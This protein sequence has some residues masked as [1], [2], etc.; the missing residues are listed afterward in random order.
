M[1]KLDR[2]CATPPACL[3]SYQHG[4]HTWDDVSGE[5]KKEIH[6][7]LEQM[8]G[9]RCAYCEGPL[10]SLGWHIE[11]FRRKSAAHFPHLTFAWSNLYW[12]CDQND[13]CGHYKDHGA[14]SYNPNDLI[15]PCN[16][17]PSHF[18]RFRSDGTV[19]VRPGLSPSDEFRARETLRTFN[20]HDEFGRLRNMRKA[21]VSSYLLDV[22]VVAS[23]SVDDRRSYAH[24]EIAAAA[25]KPFGTVIQHLFED[26][27]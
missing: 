27:L 6:A 9:R 11:H 23:W 17:D 3:G 26:F 25:D 8:Q 19:T 2:S 24:Q 15:D 22:E 7:S 1:R 18:L 20:L 5:H 4:H 12:S 21:A 10:D 13:S 14:G 16:H